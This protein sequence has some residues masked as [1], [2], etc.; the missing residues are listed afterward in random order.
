MI[1]IYSSHGIFTC[2]DD[3]Q[4]LCFDS[5]GHCDDGPACHP[6]LTL[7]HRFDVD[8]AI[9]TAGGGD[10]LNVGDHWL[11]GGYEPPLESWS[12]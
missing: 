2:T 5:T 9:V 3:G 10:I 4:V 6:H 1:R 12:D 8:A 7:T 11:G